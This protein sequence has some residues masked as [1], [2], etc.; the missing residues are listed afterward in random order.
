MGFLQELGYES[1]FVRTV[2]GDPSMDV[3]SPVGTLTTGTVGTRDTKLSVPGNH[4]DLL[5]DNRQTCCA[6]KSECA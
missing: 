6:S 1:V 3:E 2:K 4:F 5:F